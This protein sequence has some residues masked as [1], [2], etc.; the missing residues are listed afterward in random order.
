MRENTPLS[1]DRRSALK[2]IGGA[3]VVGLGAG[4][5]SQTAAAATSDGEL[6]SSHDYGE[7]SGTFGEQY[8]LENGAYV[9]QY[10]SYWDEDFSDVFVHRIQ[11]SSHSIVYQGSELGDKSQEESRLVNDS[12]SVDWNENDLISVTTDEDSYPY[13]GTYENEELKDQKDQ[14]DFNQIANSVISGAIALA[15]VSASAPVAVGT[16]M[17]AAFIT[18]GGDS[19]SQSW[20]YDW[21]GDADYKHETNRFGRVDIRQKAGSSCTLSFDVDANAYDAYSNF[22][23][24]NN[25]EVTLTAPE[26]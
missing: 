26:Q 11:V 7:G 25:L 1:V 8:W 9:E 18:S 4:L 13:V 22:K 12:L 2:K 14:N 19:T 15:T 23:A 17:V 6:A 21:G 24:N 16:S 20:S 5:G 3:T 10:N